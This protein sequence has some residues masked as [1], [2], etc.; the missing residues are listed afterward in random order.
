MRQGWKLDSVGQ[1]DAANTARLMEIV[2]VLS[3]LRR[4]WLL[5]VPG[6]FLAMLAGMSMVYNVSLNPPGLASRMTT[7]ASRRHRAC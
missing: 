5:V 3:V 2:S 7:A 4:Y 6:F 1:R